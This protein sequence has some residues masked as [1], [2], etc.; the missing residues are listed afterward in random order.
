V[1]LLT[2]WQATQ[3][4][5]E[6]RR[7]M[8]ST[9]AILV[10]GLVLLAVSH[11]RPA[12]TPMTS[13]PA[14]P[15]VI[16]LMPLPQAPA[17]SSAQPLGPRQREA[18]QPKPAPPNPQATPDRIDVPTPSEIALP[19][20]SPS[21]QES[22]PEQL[23]PAPQTSAPPGEQASAS[24]Q[25]S[26]PQQAARSLAQSA[27]QLSFR[28]RLLGHLERYKRYPASAQARR[29]QGAPQV[30]FTMDRAGHLLASK[31]ERASSYAV[32]DVEA[33]ALLERAQPLPALPDEVVGDT[34]EI[35]V[36]IEFFLS[37]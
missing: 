9:L 20:F 1:K 14:L 5:L 28:E 16:E 29:Q 4:R 25:T 23:P 11:W 18:P 19:A 22:P 27:A 35:V 3:D 30:R 6:R 15:M 12:A 8:A 21:A 31:L 2:E 34:L 32:L 13:P 37:R 10:C 24:D 17:E 7:W 33:L 26:A 36:P